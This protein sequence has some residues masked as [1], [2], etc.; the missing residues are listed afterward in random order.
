MTSNRKPSGLPLILAA[1]VLVVIILLAFF[2]VDIAAGLAVLV[3]IVTAWLLRR[4]VIGVRSRRAVREAEGVQAKAFR[5]IWLLVTV[6]LLVGCAIVL[7]LTV[8]PIFLAGEAAEISAPLQETPEEEPAPEE[9]EE[10]PSAEE[11]EAEEEP[12]ER[13]VVVCPDVIITGVEVIVTARDLTTGALEVGGMATAYAPGIDDGNWDECRDK[14]G[15]PFSIPLPTTT[16]SSRKRGLLL[17]EAVVDVDEAELVSEAFR[18]EGTG[19]FVRRY[20]TLNVKLEDFPK[21]SF[22]EARNTSNL[23]SRTYL[24]TETVTWMQTAYDPATFSYLPPAT[25]FARPVLSLSYRIGSVGEAVVGLGSF[26][27]SFALAS[28][29]ESIIG[30]FAKERLGKLFRRSGGKS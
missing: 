22:F 20:D 7:A 4:L 1:A 17:K 21:G 8:S 16:V 27:G 18:R 5:P 9:P 28:A 29:F 19:T 3:G 6:I 24:N 11:P 26:A 14:P 10:E 2:S 25:R 12:V 30:D 15:E 23:Q 13:E